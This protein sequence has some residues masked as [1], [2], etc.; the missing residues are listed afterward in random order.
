V[1][2]TGSTFVT[3]TLREWWLEHVVER[4]RR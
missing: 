2:V 4:S 1:V 3:G